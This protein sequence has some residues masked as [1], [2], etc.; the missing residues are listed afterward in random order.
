MTCNC[1]VEYYSAPLPAAL[2][3]ETRPT[4]ILFHFHHLL[5]W[6]TSS[7][8]ISKIHSLQYFGGCVLMFRTSQLTCDIETRDTKLATSV[9]FKLLSRVNWPQYDVFNCNTGYFQLMLTTFAELIW[10]DGT[11]NCVLWNDNFPI[12]RCTDS[13]SVLLGLAF[14]TSRSWRTF[15][16]MK[17][18]FMG[19][20]QNKIQESKFYTYV[21]HVVVLLFKFWSRAI[22]FCV[23]KINNVG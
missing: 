17:F 7:L 9:T 13:F 20:K 14:C 2:L 18:L 3:I 8:V 1:F 11:F 10:W 6:P 19:S 12:F 5:Y 21:R 22:Y 16:W 4:N 23:I 15:S